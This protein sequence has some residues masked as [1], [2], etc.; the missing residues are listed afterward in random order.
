MAGE[1][2]GGK[3]RVETEG[4]VGDGARMG[5]VLGWDLGRKAELGQRGCQETSRRVDFLLASEEGARW[6]LVQKKSTKRWRGEERRSGGIMGS[7]LV[8]GV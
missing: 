3:T 4:E 2:K 8:V 6:W 7:T 1:G 5:F